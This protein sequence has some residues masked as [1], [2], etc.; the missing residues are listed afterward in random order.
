MPMYH[1]TMQHYAS[2]VYAIIVCLSVMPSCQWPWVSLKVT[3]YFK[4]LLRLVLDLAT[5]EGCKAEFVS[6]SVSCA[7]G[8]CPSYSFIIYTD[9]IWHPCRQ[10]AAISVLFAN[11]QCLMSQ[12]FNDEL[13]WA[14]SHIVHISYWWM[15]VVA[16]CLA[17][18]S[19]AWPS[20]KCLVNFGREK[21]RSR[22]LSVVDSLLLHTCNFS[23]SFVCHIVH[24]MSVE[25]KE[26]S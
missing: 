9:R 3:C 8:I 10:L 15:L 24:V 16:S 7:V 11:E 26:I 1:F 2:V 13:I 20:L 4:P 12:A 18:A 17:A 23:F 25:S 6:W 21:H 19:K 22:T 5:P 14:A